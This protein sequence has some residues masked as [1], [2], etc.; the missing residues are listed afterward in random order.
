[1][2]DIVL[3]LLICQ[4]KDSP[5]NLLKVW[6]KIPGVPAATLYDVL[7]DPDY[8]KTWDDNMEEVLS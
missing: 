5:I 8:R 1:M 6:A 7:H 2:L 3:N 4:A